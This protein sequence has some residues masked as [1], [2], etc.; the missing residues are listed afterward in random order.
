M[1]H[2]LGT[3]FLVLCFVVCATFNAQEASAKSNNNSAVVSTSSTTGIKNLHKEVK[4]IEIESAQI[5]IDA[6]YLKQLSR[7]CKFYLRLQ[8]GNKKLANSLELDFDK[9]LKWVVKNDYGGSYVDVPIHFHVN[10]LHLDNDSEIH[11]CLMKILPK[12]SL[13][14]LLRPWQIFS[15]SGLRVKPKASIASREICGI[16]ERGKIFQRFGTLGYGVDLILSPAS[17]TKLSEL[18]PLTKRVGRRQTYFSV[19]A[20]GLPFGVKQISE[21]W[22]YPIFAQYLYGPKDDPNPKM[23]M[24]YLLQGTTEEITLPKKDERELVPAFDCFF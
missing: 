8:H 24:I 9:L 1:K 23:K 13:K 2:R 5:Y 18:P 3:F 20:K 10:P 21:D 14:K 19:M 4:M 16:K 12:F 15:K 22:R 7:G 6:K 11:C 17:W